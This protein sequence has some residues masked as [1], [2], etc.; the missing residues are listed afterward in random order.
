MTFSDE[1]L[2]RA[3]DPLYDQAQAERWFGRKMP[4]ASYKGVVSDSPPDG[5]PRQCG[6]CGCDQIQVESHQHEVGSCAF[7]ARRYCRNCEWAGPRGFGA[8]IFQAVDD[9]TRKWNEA[10][11]TPSAIGFPPMVLEGAVDHLLRFGRPKEGS[12]R[13]KAAWD[14]VKKAR[15]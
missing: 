11:P 7:M 12:D 9:A 15:G 10:A 13:Y 6:R 8:T 5:S 2:V 14:A 1:D 3:A 4:P